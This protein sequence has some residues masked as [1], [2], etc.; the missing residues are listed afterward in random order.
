MPRNICVHTKQ[1]FYRGFPKFSST[2]KN[3]F[4]ITNNRDKA[5]KIHNKSF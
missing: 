4:A 3:L 5:E 1:K 2:P